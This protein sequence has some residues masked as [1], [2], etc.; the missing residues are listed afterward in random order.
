MGNACQA[1]TEAD[2]QRVV[3]TVL[4][5]P[6]CLVSQQSYCCSVDD[7][8]MDAFEYQRLEA[9]FPEVPFPEESESPNVQC[10]I[11]RVALAAHGG[12]HRIAAKVAGLSEHRPEG[13]RKRVR[14]HPSPSFKKS[15]PVDK[16]ASVSRAREGDGMDKENAPVNVVAQPKPSMVKSRP[17]ASMGPPLVQ[18]NTAPT[19]AVVSVHLYDL[20]EALAQLNS[21]AIDLMGYGGALHVGVEVFGVEWSF[22]TGG[23]SLS[24]PKQ[25]HYYVFRQTVSMG[26]S[27]LTQKEVQ[28][29]VMDMQREWKGSEYD[30]FLKNCGTFSNAL[31]LRLGVGNLPAWITRLAEDAGRSSTVQRIVDVMAQNGLIGEASPLSQSQPSPLH[32]SQQCG[33]QT[34][35]ELD[36]P[37]REFDDE[38]DC[39]LSRLSGDDWLEEEL[40]CHLDSP[41]LRNIS[42][43]SSSSNSRCSGLTRSTSVQQGI[44]S[45]ERGSTRP[46]RC[47][48]FHAN[49][50][51]KGGQIRANSYPQMN[52]ASHDDEIYEDGD[53]R[54]KDFCMKR[55]GIGPRPAFS[56]DPA[57][58]AE[59]VGAIL[60]E[61]R[62]GGA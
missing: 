45:P 6:D 51:H 29:I 33:S 62:N 34:C 15:A 14:E 41:P 18:A 13:F 37:P 8:C 56:K 31:C 30:L 21:V 25:N 23:V 2:V 19:G 9:R 58:L 20:S 3:C 22:G 26:R 36:S 52:G 32:R 54:M 59:T 12:S 38:L 47:A 60:T 57:N 4:E 28:R 46:R 35:I 16:P 48:N 5:Q 61:A 17:S 53:D 7:D 49:S 55:L 50:R 39:W 24:M 11:P 27:H 10:S 42:K 1:P 43:P 44:P 40:G